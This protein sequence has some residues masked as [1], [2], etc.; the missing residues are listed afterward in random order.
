MT[1][2]LQ[3]HH[4]P[5]ESHEELENLE[6]KVVVLSIPSGITQCWENLSNNEQHGPDWP[7]HNEHD[8]RCNL[9]KGT[10]RYMIIPG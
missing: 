10:E 1:I 3:E 2:K 5:D 8:E 6:V 9:C 7:G 4:D